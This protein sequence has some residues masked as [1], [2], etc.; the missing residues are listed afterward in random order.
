MNIVK[1]LVARRSALLVTVARKTY[2]YLRQEGYAPKTAMA[3]AAFVGGAATQL[4]M[5]AC[6]MTAK[7]VAGPV[8]ALVVYGV[9]GVAEVAMW[10]SHGSEMF[11]PAGLQDLVREAIL[12]DAM[13][14]QAQPAFAN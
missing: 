5:A 9:F 2:G 7:I 4:P 6:V 8:G 3:G 13:L 11:Q 1:S 12:E 10:K 14:A